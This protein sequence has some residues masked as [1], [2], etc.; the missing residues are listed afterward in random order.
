MQAVIDAGAGMINDVLAL[1][2]PGAL[3]A[4]APRTRRLA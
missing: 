1:R 4:V 3:E 2:T